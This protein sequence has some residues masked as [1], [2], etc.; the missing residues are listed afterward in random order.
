MFLFQQ[1]YATG[2]SQ[3]QF[4]DP[5]A[6]VYLPRTSNDPL[7]RPKPETS[8]SNS[9]SEKTSHKRDDESEQSS[10]KNDDDLDGYIEGVQFDKL[11][12]LATP[13]PQSPL[14]QG[15]IPSELI[16]NFKSCNFSKMIL[17]KNKVIH[18]IF[19]RNSNSDT[20]KDLWIE[21]RK[22]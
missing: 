20:R 13:N 1:Q 6:N 19:R 16:Y 14:I 18:M 11:N 15:S 9:Q 17:Q 8:N 7:N 4:K 2:S 21:P 10:S 12:P 22:S 5:C 3:N